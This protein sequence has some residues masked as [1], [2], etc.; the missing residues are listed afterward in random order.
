MVELMEQL[1]SIAAD[2][3]PE[4]SALLHAIGYAL[5]M[6]TPWEVVMNDPRW[7]FLPLHIAYTHDKLGTPD[8]VEGVFFER[9]DAE[10]LAARVAQGQ[11]ANHPLHHQFYKFKVAEWPLGTLAI[12][13]ARDSFHHGVVKHMVMQIK[14]VLR[15]AGKLPQGVAAVSVGSAGPADSANDE[16][17]AY[18]D[19]TGRRVVLWEDGCFLTG[20]SETIDFTTRSKTPLCGLMNGCGDIVVPPAFQRVAPLCNGLAV[21]MRRGKVGYIDAAGEVAIPFIYEDAADCC[22]ELLLVKAGGLWGAIDLEGNEVIPPRFESLEHDLGNEALRAQ[23]DGKHGYLSLS[24]DLLA[25]YSEQP[26]QLAEQ[27]FATERSVFIARDTG[28]SD[29]AHVLVDAQGRRIGLQSFANIQY[30]FH[31]E[32]LLCASVQEG[33][34]RRHGY[35]SLHGETVIGFRFAAAENF[36]EGLAAAVADEPGP[37]HYGYIDRQGNWAIEPMFEHAGEFHQGLAVASGMAHRPWHWRVFERA[38]ARRIDDF[39]SGLL[40]QSVGPGWRRPP[41]AP[42][43]RRYGYIDRKGN[44]VVEQRFLEARP[45]NE[46]LAPVRTEKGWAY[47]DTRGTLVTPAYYQ[48]AGPVK[49]GVA[50]V[51]R[52][53]DG[54]LRYGLVDSGGREIIPLRFDWLSYPKRGLIT[55]CDEYG[56]WGCFTL[57]GNIVAPFIYRQA[58]DLHVALA[59]RGPAPQ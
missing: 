50:R 15:Q 10:G 57:F 39:C 30:S 31:D 56:L 58:R 16:L 8:T 20:A 32:G 42:G 37:R 21:A 24:G 43:M 53:F 7:A 26:V 59:V 2:G 29:V 22:Q 51:A 1:D 52:R 12:R 25:G 40:D 55:A 11:S 41:A 18:I 17:L 36:S 46:G 34:R 44:W 45:F 4:P 54:L 35:I 27:S 33:Q 6:G 14:A 5:L 38:F 13:E 48:E 49:Q 9:D 19:V 47:I 23:R 28:A 3:T